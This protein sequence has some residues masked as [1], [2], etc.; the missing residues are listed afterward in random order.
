MIAIKRVIPAPRALSSL[1]GRNRYGYGEVVEVLHRMQHG[2]CCYCEMCIAESRSGRH[3]EHYR[4][5]SL[6]PALTYQWNNLLLACADCN[7]AKLDKFPY[8]EDRKPLLIDPSDPSADP[9][10]HIEFVVRSGQK[11]PHGIDWP[12]GLAVARNHSA[13]GKA[14]IETIKLWEGHHIGR[15]TETYKKLRLCYLLLREEKGKVDQ[16]NGDTQRVSQLRSELNSA[17]DDDQ[18]YAGLA[19]SFLREHPI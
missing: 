17:A 14:T 6:F 1:V 9:E 3:V 12:V 4:P 13:R 19:R 11:G 16:G 15:R 5:K 2:K 7:S 10:D 8:S 18:A